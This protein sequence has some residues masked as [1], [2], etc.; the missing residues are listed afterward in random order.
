MADPN[1]AV[2][3]IFKNGKKFAKAKAE[4][5]Y[6]EEYRKS[7]K[8]ILMKRSVENAIGAQERDA[9]AHDEYLALLQ[10]L[11]AAVEVEEELRWA[12]IAAQARVEIWRSQ[13]ATNRVE[14]KVTI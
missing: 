13:E 1:E 6:L 8:A 7:L 14:G 5:I 12:L 10:G 11:K 2:D 3:Y 4:R 9:Y